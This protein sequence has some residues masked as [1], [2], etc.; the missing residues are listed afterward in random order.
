[1]VDFSNRQEIKYGDVAERLKA[2]HSKCAVGVTP[3]EVRI[4]PSP[5]V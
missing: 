3:P 2:A 5:P 1:M 4:L